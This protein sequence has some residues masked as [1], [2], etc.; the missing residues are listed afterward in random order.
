M[1]YCVTKFFQN[2]EIIKITKNSIWL[3]L[4]KIIRM[5]IGL[6][7]GVW[8][9][10][11][12]GPDQFGKLNYARAIV[13]L[14]GFLATLGL[15]SLVVRDLVR[16]PNNKEKL[17]GSTFILRLIG[18]FLS[19]MLIII[20]IKIIRPHEPMIFVLVCI[21]SLGLLFQIFDTI[22]F[23]F[24]AQLLSKYTV[25]S[26]NLAY[27]VASAIKVLLIVYKMP[28]IS[29]AIIGSFEILIGSCFLLI[30]NRIKDVRITKWKPSLMTMKLLLLESW[31]LI[32]ASMASMINMRIDQIFI[33]NILDDNAVGNYAAAIRISEIWLMIPSILGVSI[34][35]Y[36][37]KQKELNE[38]L[39]RKKLHKVFQLLCFT[40]IPIALLISSI[41]DQVVYL[42]YGIQYQIAGKLLSIH[43]WSGVPYLLTFVYAQMYYIEGLTRIIFY[44]SLLTPLLNISLNL[45]L[46][47]KLGSVGAAI[48]TMITAVLTG[49][50]SMILLNKKTGIFCGKIV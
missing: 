32:L 1:L 34:F 24:Q 29:F 26:K 27:L 4:D 3:L 50:I 48:A 6:F 37:I 25:I 28:L 45:I 33:G 43:I 10:R 39:Y 8:V 19:F 17:L 36:M 5:G 11:Y 47:P 21:S 31:P 23:S 44:T 16:Y 22:D 7:V 41:S 18:S 42:L 15:D 2:K 9:A 13:G 46:I 38:D 14:F 12:L 20:A 30:V 35:P 49:I 40:I